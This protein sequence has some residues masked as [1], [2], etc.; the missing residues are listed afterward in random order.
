MKDFENSFITV[1]LHAGSVQNQLVYR[2]I[3]SLNLLR[4]S[5]KWFDIGNVGTTLA[6]KGDFW[7]RKNKIGCFQSKIAVTFVLL[8]KKRRSVPWTPDR[9][10]SYN[11]FENFSDEE[12]AKAIDTIKRLAR[13]LLDIAIKREEDS[14][15]ATLPNAF[16]LTHQVS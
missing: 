9:L 16:L 12:A 2:T 11:G 4:F 15:N 3:R 13:I 14:P 6:N 8:L 1:W 10:R 5:I 7:M